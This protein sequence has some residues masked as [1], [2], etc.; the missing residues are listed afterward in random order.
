[1]TDD[2]DLPSIDPDM[3]QTVTG[4]AADS[5]M[6][7]MMM[8]MM[9]MMMKKNHGGGGDVQSAAP[10]AAPRTEQCTCPNCGTQTTMTRL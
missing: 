6:S 4:G 2:V 9:M 1:M 3:L 10:A 5:G 7:G 8:P